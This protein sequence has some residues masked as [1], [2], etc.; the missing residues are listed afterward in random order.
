[1]RVGLIVLVTCI[2]FLWQTPQ[3]E[4][5]AQITGRPTSIAPTITLAPTATPRTKYLPLIKQTDPTP[6][7]TSTPEPTRNPELCAPEYPTV[8]IPPP[9]P[10]LNCAEIEFT[11]FPV[12]S[13]DR[14][15]FDTDRDGIGC[16]T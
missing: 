16:E 4:T 11:N 9:P 2:L 13:P 14:H 15:R 5:T 8:C 10:D 7:A 12:F 3:S 1:M 6:T